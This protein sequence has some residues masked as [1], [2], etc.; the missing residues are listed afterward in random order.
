M[1]K[2]IG[3]DPG[4]VQSAV[5]VWDT[6]TKR[7]LVALLKPNGEILSYLKLV[8]ADFCAIEMVQSF[9]MSVGAEVFETVYFIGRFAEAWDQAKENPGI[10]PDDY[11]FHPA[12]RI[13]RS[14]VKMHLCHSMQAK[15]SNI[16]QALIDR[17]G[18]PGTKRAPGLTYGIAGD[19]WSA[20]AVAVSFCDRIAT[21]LL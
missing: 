13:F 19:L 10:L 6:D 2:I 5:V 18:K 4:P 9:G 11:E 7:I 1:S 17:L 16:R 8:H 21:I 15:D 3:V 14:D 20:L 12:E